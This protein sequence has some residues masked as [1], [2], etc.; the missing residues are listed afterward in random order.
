MYRTEAIGG[1]FAWRWTV[2]GMAV[3]NIPPAGMEPT[4]EKAMRSF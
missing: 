1:G 4:R 3:H 2:Y